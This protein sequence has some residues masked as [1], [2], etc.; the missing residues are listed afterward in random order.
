MDVDHIKVDLDVNV[1]VDVDVDVVKMQKLLFIYN[2]LETG[3]SVRKRANKF[4]F[5]KKHEGK[6]EVYLEEYLQNFIATNMALSP[7]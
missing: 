1:D 2:A 3:W 4:I 5:T 6:K 7:R